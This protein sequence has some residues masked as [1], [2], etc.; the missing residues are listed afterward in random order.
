MF[1]ISHAFTTLKQLFVNGNAMKSSS[2][3]QGDNKNNA[4]L[5][6]HSNYLPLKIEDK[7]TLEYRGLLID[8]SKTLYTSFTN[9]EN[10]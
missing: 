6:L 7:P 10:Y 4:K 1:G 8:T 5:M 3:I 9:S 2:T